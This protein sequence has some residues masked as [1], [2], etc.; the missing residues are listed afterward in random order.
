MFIVGI[1]NSLQQLIVSG[2]RLIGLPLQSVA[3]GT[4]REGGHYRAEYLP[5]C[6]Y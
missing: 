3:S 2:S 1:L 6:G 4:R 5:C